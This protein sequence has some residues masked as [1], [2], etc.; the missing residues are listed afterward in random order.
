[1]ETKFDI[2]KELISS[3]GIIFR[4]LREMKGLSLEELSN[5]LKNKYN[6]N[7]SGNMLGKFE[8]NASKWQIEVF[9]ALI[10]YY[11]IQLEDIHPIFQIKSENESFGKLLRYS[12]LNPDLEFILLNLQKRGSDHS[13]LHLLK[14]NIENLLEFIEKTTPDLASDPTKLQDP[15]TM[16]AASRPARNPNYRK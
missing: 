1:M 8:R 13:F 4:N 11:S 3:I 15:Y 12:E 7:V 16:K 9:L 6:I 10:H 5:I 14:S 2:Y